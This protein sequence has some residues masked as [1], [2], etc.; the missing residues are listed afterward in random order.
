[1]DLRCPAGNVFCPEPEGG[2]QPAS[3]V[4]GT[5][6]HTH[7]ARRLLGVGANPRGGVTAG[8]TIHLRPSPLT[9]GRRFAVAKKKKGKKKPMK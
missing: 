3:L 5:P 6:D 2:K 1:L 7:A 9:R 4:A 8:G